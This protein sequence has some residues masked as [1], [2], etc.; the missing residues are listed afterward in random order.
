[1][2]VSQLD[3]TGK[4]LAGLQQYVSNA[5]V[6]I[7]FNPDVEA[8]PEV[9]DRNASGALAVTWRI[10]D[11]IKR[12]TMTVELITPDPELEVILTGGTT[13]V[14]ATNNVEGA[15]YPPIMVESVPNGV[16]IEAWTRAVVN[17]AQPTDYPW[18]RWVFPKVKLRKGN[19]TLD[20]NRLASPFEGFGFENAQFGTGPGKDIPYDAS[21]VAQWFRDTTYPT[22]ALGA[23]KIT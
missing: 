21:R 4:P 3:G 8:G 22:P 19:R 14:S 13:Y 10:M 5:L 20:I 11:V 7:D 6:R 2:R 1:M 15:Q 12:L 18:M 17:G 23:T 9:S 16:G